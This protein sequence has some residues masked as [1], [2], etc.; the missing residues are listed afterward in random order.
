MDTY[1]A[2]R[3]QDVEE[4]LAALGDMRNR[5]EEIARA[6]AARHSANAR[7]NAERA[8]MTR[9]DLAVAH[10]SLSIATAYIHCIEFYRTDGER[11]AI[12]ETQP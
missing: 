7:R 11:A 4:R 3:F 5:A 2:S 6:V 1:L 9:Q 8:E 10:D 12:G